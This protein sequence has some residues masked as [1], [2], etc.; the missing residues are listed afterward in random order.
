MTHNQ[1]A[2]FAV[3]NTY[4]PLPDQ[5][6]VPLAQ[7]LAP[8]HQSSSGI[9]SRRAELCRMGRVEEV[10]T[11]TTSSGRSASVWGTA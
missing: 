5:A 1:E 11:I 8:V 3:L 10:G 2:V 6:L 9:R 7:H 4:G